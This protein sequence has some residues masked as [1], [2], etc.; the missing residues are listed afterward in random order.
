M[1]VCRRYLAIIR[2][3]KVRR[4]E[5]DEN[6][7][8]RKKTERKRERGRGREREDEDNERAMAGRWQRKGEKNGRRDGG[9]RR[10]KKN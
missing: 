4:G 10:R 8:T 9:T 3:R 1:P 7:S 2:A 6:G 5:K